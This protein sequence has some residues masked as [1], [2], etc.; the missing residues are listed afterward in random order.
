MATAT[1]IVRHRVEDYGSWRSV[2][3][4]VEPLRQ[5]YG[6]TGAEVNVDPS[7]KNDVWV[8]HRFPSLEQAEGFASSAELKDA[9]GRA[10]VAGPPRIEIVVEA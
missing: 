2:Y 1:L 6:C 10:G 7:D 8:L 9:M 4:S 5:Q 3:D